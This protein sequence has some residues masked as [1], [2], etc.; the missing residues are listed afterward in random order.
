MICP[1]CQRPIETLD[2]EVVIRALKL[3]PVR[4]TLALV[5]LAR[6]GQ[7]ST[8]KQLIQLVYGNRKDGAPRAADQCVDVMFCYLRHA[9]KPF[10]VV[11][12][13][14]IGGIGGRRMAP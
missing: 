1:C 4:T 10:G 5:L 11:L 14:R 13:S 7:W 2:M 3:G 12:E 9:L 6:R 8:N